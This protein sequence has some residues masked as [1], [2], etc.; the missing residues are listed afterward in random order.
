M[1][2]FYF[3]FQDDEGPH[4]EKEGGEATVREWTLARRVAKVGKARKLPEIDRV[5]NYR[6]PDDRRNEHDKTRD[7]RDGEALLNPV[8]DAFP[9]PRDH[10]AP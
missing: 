1:P 2:R 4:H 3:D 10:P 9:I 7:R 8:H 6:Q 5:L